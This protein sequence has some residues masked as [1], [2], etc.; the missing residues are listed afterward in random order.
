MSKFLFRE[1]YE[2]EFG[3]NS[4]KPTST[5]ELLLD[6]ILSDK[7]RLGK[8]LDIGTG[9]GFIILMLE[10]FE[11][12][13]FGSCASDLSNEN[14]KYFR[15]NA[16]KFKSNIEI[17]LGSLF[18]PWPN[19]RFDTIINDI[20]G[21]VPEIAQS[22]GWFDGVPAQCGEDGAELTIEFLNQSLEYLKYDG[23]IYTPILSLQNE[24]RI[25]QT[26]DKMNLK[27]EVLSSRYWFL[28]EV[29]SSNDILLDK[30]LSQG[31]IRLEKK[32]GKYCWYTTIL[33]LERF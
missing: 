18:E 24:N 9:I 6:S 31:Y 25:Y 27:Y 26:I 11:K 15:I 23:I 20:S 33:K 2:F 30:L 22:S 29:L 8:T 1:Q 13:D 16:N 7:N 3:K 14:I 19:H 32:F 12:L 28:P 21:V 10:K 4:F 17:K 5:S